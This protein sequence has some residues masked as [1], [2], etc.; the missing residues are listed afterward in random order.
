MGKQKQASHQQDVVELPRTHWPS[1]FM[2]YK[3]FEMPTAPAWLAHHPESLAHHPDSLAHRPESHIDFWS[4]GREVS[5]KPLS[6]VWRSLTC[7]GRS[8]V[9][10]ILVRAV[11]QHGLVHNYWGIT[12]ALASLGDLLLL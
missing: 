6:G 5:M 11:A 7:S 10:V 12:V 2:C 8:L 4:Y 3:I 1:C 9:P